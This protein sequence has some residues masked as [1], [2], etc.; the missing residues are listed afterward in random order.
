M[1]GVI[2]KKCGYI[3]AHESCETVFKFLGR[4]WYKS[5]QKGILDQKILWDNVW[6]G[7][8]NSVTALLS[9][10]PE[11]HEKF[12]TPIKHHKRVFII[13]AGWDSN[14]HHFMLDSLTRLTRHITFLKNNQDI[15]IHIRAIEQSFKKPDY[16]IA[17]R[18]LRER[19]FAMVRTF[20]TY[21]G[22][23]TDFAQILMIVKFSTS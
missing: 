22:D 20:C 16:I 19:L 10:C 4:N 1:T 23:N 15:M 7:S 11:K 13:T 14:Y 3:Q 17:G 21:S 6:D 8:N 9:A 2:A 5:C 12:S 18:E